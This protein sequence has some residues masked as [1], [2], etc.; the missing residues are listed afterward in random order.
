MHYGRTFKWPN[1]TNIFLKLILY[2]IKTKWCFQ[3][4]DILVAFFFWWVLDDVLLWLCYRMM[5][6]CFFDLCRMRWK[7][8]VVDCPLMLVSVFNVVE[9]FFDGE[10]WLP[11]LCRTSV[12]LW[13]VLGVTGPEPRSV[14]AMFFGL[15][16]RGDGR[17]L[18]CSPSGGKCRTV[19]CGLYWQYAD[20]AEHKKF[21]LCLWL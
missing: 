1:N 19:E 10:F 18:G 20:S 15:D 17:M 13:R 12:Y 3:Q 4:Y 6:M 2:I 11:N 9:F 8:P 21:G 5:H 14:L 16:R 7:R